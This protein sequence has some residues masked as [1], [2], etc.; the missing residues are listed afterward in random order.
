V[1]IAHA[2][3]GLGPVG[4]EHSKYIHWVLGDHLLDA[5]TYAII[6]KEQALCN[7]LQLYDN[8]LAWLNKYT[9]ILSLNAKKFIRRKL[10]ETIN[11]PFNF[12]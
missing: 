9:T 3:K 8:I 11:N 1:I 12:L 6:P 2:D 7:P 10:G 5:T 4:I